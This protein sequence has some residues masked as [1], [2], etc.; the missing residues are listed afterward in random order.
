MPTGTIPARSGGTAGPVPPVCVPAGPN[1]VGATVREA[2]A[3][4]K[5]VGGPHH[6]DGGSRAR[7][8]TE[9]AGRGSVRLQP[10]SRKKM[11]A[12]AEAGRARL[13]TAAPGRQR[14]ARLMGVGTEASPAASGGSGRTQNPRADVDDER[15]A[16]REACA[17]GAGSLR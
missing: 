8:P 16:L 17:T 7:C 4:T 15:A 10:S 12:A 2:G 1:G 9:R 11:P 5:G 3:I 13:L 6:R 14:P